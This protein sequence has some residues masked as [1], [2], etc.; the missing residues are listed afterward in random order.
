MNTPNALQDHEFRTITRTLSALLDQMGRGDVDWVIV[1]ANP[2]E[3]VGEDGV[4]SATFTNMDAIPSAVKLLIHAAREMVER[5]MD[6][7][8]SDAGEGDA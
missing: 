1:L 3:R 7:E 6:D 8:W 2:R 4:R 5:P